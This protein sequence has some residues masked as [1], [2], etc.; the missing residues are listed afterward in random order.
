MTARAGATIP[1]AD[2]AAL[3]AHGLAPNTFRRFDHDDT[4]AAL[5]R[6]AAAVPERAAA[7]AFV[8]GLGSA[9]R[10]WQAL[11]PAWA[12]GTTMPE[13]PGPTGDRP[14]DVCFLTAQTTVDT[15]LAWWQR[16][17]SGSPLPG[18][19][20]GYLLALESAT[21]PP[22][23][24]QPH[25][26]WV[27]HEILDIV[28]SLPPTTRAGAAAQALRTAGLLPGADKW[29]YR[30][31]L[32]DLAFVGVLQT[33]EH[34]GMLTA[35]TTARQRDRRPSVRVEVDAPLAFWRAADGVT[36]PLVRRLFGHLPRP[37]ERPPAPATA[38]PVRRAQPGTRST[39]LP[40]AL[41]GEPRAGDLYAV[42]CR[43]DAWV[44]AYC[45]RID[46]LGG[47]RYGLVE[48]LDGVFTT[49]PSAADVV[50]AD[51]ALSRPPRGR[52]SDR[53]QMRASRL[54]KTTGVRRLARDVAPPVDDRPA[55]DRITNGAAKD[56]SHLASWCFPDM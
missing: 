56:L 1:A 32:E 9:S 35:F 26:V 8:A 42:R 6:L 30:S 37:A 20:C 14:C 44:V 51:G 34:P 15:T 39:P 38:A 53:W 33:P 49:Q 13:H 16:A 29:T 50:D 12:L 36:E 18:D 31:L 28:R 23:V 21:T 40:A 3:G 41:R 11:L 43:S 25:D 47:R 5:R 22:P 52:G 24:P 4:V 19:V 46:D 7:D 45:H 55:P 27:L 48:Y 2:L 54:D 17:T 10:N